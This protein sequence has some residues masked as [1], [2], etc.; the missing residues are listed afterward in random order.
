MVEIISF[1][2][3]IEHDR[4]RAR[5]GVLRRRLGP[6]GSQGSGPV[7]SPTLVAAAAT[8]LADI[9]RLISREPGA[10]TL[11]RLDPRQAVTH[12]QLAGML[13][14]ADLKLALFQDAHSDHDGDTG[15]DWL[16]IEGIEALCEDRES[17]PRP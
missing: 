1:L 10:R 17:Y 8:L 3:V 11:P 6:T 14:D 15:D 7:A 12:Q 4:L 5:L 2:K 9:Y 16:T 13:A